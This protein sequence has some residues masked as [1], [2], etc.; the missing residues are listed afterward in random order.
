MRKRRDRESIDNY[1]QALNDLRNQCE[2][3]ICCRRV[4]WNPF[5]AGLRSTKLIAALITD[6]EGKPFEDTV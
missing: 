1:S 6:C 4:L 5:I 3:K 2:Y